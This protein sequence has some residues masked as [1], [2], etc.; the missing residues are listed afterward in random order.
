VNGVEQVLDPTVAYVMTPGQTQRYDHPDDG[1]DSCTWL[2]LGPSLAE[3]LGVLD[4]VEHANG[5][6]QVRPDVD[7]AHR[8]VLTESRRGEDHHEVAESGIALVAHVLADR[9]RSCS[10]SG[11]GS[12]SKAHRRLVD[13]ARGQLAHDLDVPLPALARMV[14]TSPHHLSR[15]FASVT[16]TTI[17]EHRRRLRARDALERLAGGEHDLSRVAAAS[18]FADHSHLVRVLRHQTGQV[19]SELRAALWATSPH[20]RA[21][22][23]PTSLR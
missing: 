3:Q 13:E 2:G 10:P 22:R 21:R 6:I 1:G 18:G 4:D 5:V 12:T 19:P 11:R 9:H 15:V 7:L 16:G 17:S 14:G 20:E 23:G 8:R